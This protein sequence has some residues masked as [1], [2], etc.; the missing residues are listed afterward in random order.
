MLSSCTN[1]KMKTVVDL[2]IKKE[3]KTKKQIY[4]TNWYIIITIDL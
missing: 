2:L 1:M 3:L 4:K